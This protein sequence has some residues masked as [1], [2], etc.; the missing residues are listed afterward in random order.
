MIYT[1]GDS[2][3][4]GYNF[5]EE[6]R[7]KFTWPH[8][9]S[10]K[11]NLPCKNISAPGGSNW[12]I[13]RQIHNLN[14]TEKDI[15]I[16]AWTEPSRFEFG[17]NKNYKQP[18]IKEGRIGDLIEEHEEYKVKRFFNQL[19]GR[20]NDQNARLFNQLA[21]SVYYNE[22]WFEEMF[23]IIFSSCLYILNNKKCNWMMFNTWTNQFSSSNS[24]FDTP[25][26]IFNQKNMNFILR[27]KD[28]LNYWNIEEHKHAACILFDSYKELYL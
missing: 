6:D 20:T 9:F 26:Y 23:K 5:T 7:K 22:K 12:R 21:Y 19:S 10:N 14:L 4:Y 11:L 2:F 25:Q 24:L 18:L 13:A 17:V 28:D 3:T 16:I 15:V 27:N 8:F 1:L